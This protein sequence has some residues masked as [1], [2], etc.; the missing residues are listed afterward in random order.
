MAP[1]RRS[2]RTARRSMPRLAALLRKE[3]IRPDRPMLPGDDGFRFCHLLI[4]DAAYDALPKATRA[5]LHERFADWLEQHGADLVERD[6]IL[7]YHLEQ[8]Y[9]YRTELGARRRRNRRARRT[10]R[11]PPRSRRPA[12][13]QSRRLARRGQAAGERARARHRRPA[14]ARPDPGRPCLAPQRARRRRSSRRSWRRVWPPQRTWGSEASPRSCSSAATGNVWRGSA[15]RPRGV[16]DGRRGGDRD[17][18]G[19]R[20]PTRPCRGR[21]GARKSASAPGPP[22]RMLCRGRTRARARC[23]LRRPGM[24]ADKSISTLTC[25][26][27]DGPEPVGDA[28]HRCE[29]LLESAGDDRVLDANINRCLSALLAMAGRVD[30]ATER[31]RRSEPGLRRQAEPGGGPPTGS[32]PRRRRSSPATSPAPSTS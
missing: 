14:R 8:A 1:C 11:R 31:V 16:A 12:G 17:V 32:S 30:E 20:R 7:G 13:R 25:A 24:F 22:G 4:R 5:E 9:R 3:L 21:S 27:C 15:S 6:E 23:R 10:R 29:E 18:H 19:S 26:L 28:I 2:P